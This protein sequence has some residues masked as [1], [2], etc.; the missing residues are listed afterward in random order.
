[1][2]MLFFAYGMNAQNFA[3][4]SLS[5]YY[6]SVNID[7]QVEQ[8]QYG[9]VSALKVTNVV[10]APTSKGTVYSSGV[11]NIPT[12][13]NSTVT[14][15]VNIAD[16]EIVGDINVTVTITHTWSSDLDLFLVSPAGT[17]VELST[18]NGGNADNTYAGTVFDDEATESII[19]AVV[20]YT[21]SYQPEGLLSSFDGELLVGDWT[22]MVGDDA[23]GDGGALVEWSLDVEYFVPANYDASIVD[24]P[25]L[26]GAVFPGSNDVVV[27]LSNLGVYTMT[28][29][30]VYY[31]IVNASTGASVASDVYSWSGSLDLGFSEDVTIGSFVATAGETYTITAFSD[32]VGDEDISND[33]YTSTFTTYTTEAIPYSQDFETPTG[34]VNA[35]GDN[36]DWSI[37]TAMGHGAYQDHTT[38]TGYFAGLD[39]SS[40]MDLGYFANFLTPVFDLS[41]LTAPGLFFYYQSVDDG[42]VGIGEI[43]E[44]HVDVTTDGINWTN[45]ILVITEEVN[46][47]TEF[48][49]NIMPYLGT[50]AQFRFRGVTT[51]DYQSDPS[52][53]DFEIK[54]LPDNDLAVTEVTPTGIYYN[55]TYTP[56]YPEVS[57][58]NAGGLDQ[59]TYSVNVTVTD[60]S[61]GVEVYNETVVDPA[62]ITA[63]G[64]YTCTMTTLLD[65]DFATYSITAF[66]DLT[67]DENLNNN[68]QEEV[69]AVTRWY[70]G[71]NGMP[72]NSYLMSS[73][74]YSGS[75]GNLLFS[76]G[77]NTMTGNN[78]EVF[79][80]NVDNQTWTQTISLP[81]PSVVGAATAYDDNI[82]VH[83]GSSGVYTNT[84]LSFDISTEA[85][86]PIADLPAEIAW[87]SATTNN[88]SIYLAGGYD[89]A[90]FLS[91]VY[92][93]DPVGDAWTTLADLP[94]AAMGG[95]LITVDNKL[96]YVW[97]IQGASTLDGYAMIGEIDPMDP[98]VITW[99][100]TAM[101]AELGT[102]K[103][104]A[105]PI[106]DNAFIVTSGDYASWA[107]R[108]NTYIYYMATDEWVRIDD[109]PLFNLGYAAGSFYDGATSTYVTASGYNGGFI[110]DVEYLMIDVNAPIAA[111]YMPAMNEIEVALDAT[112]SVEFNVGVN[113]LYTPTVSIFDGTDFVTVTGL[114]FDDATNTL[115]I[116]HD[117][118]DYGT[119]YSVTIDAGAFMSE[120]L[121]GSLNDDIS[122]NFTTI[123][124]TYSVTFNVDMT[125]P[126]ALGNFIVGTDVVYLTGSMVGWAEPGTDPTMEMTDVD[127]DFIYS[128]TLQVTDGDAEYKYFQNAGWDGGEWAGG[129][130]RMF[131]V[132]G[133]DLTLDDVWAMEYLIMFSVTDGT[134]ALEGASVNIDGVEDFTNVDGLVPFAAIDGTYSYTVS[135]A[136]YTVVSDDAIVAGDHQV[137]DVVLDPLA[138]NNIFANVA[139]TPNP[140]SG[141]VTISADDIYTVKVINVNGQV[142]SSMNMTNTTSTIDISNLE[143]GLYFVE[144]SNDNQSATYKIIKK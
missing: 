102:Y 132:A 82:F 114:N 7:K 28:A 92:R 118:F 104:T 88:G 101:P 16:N 50:Y 143:A 141:L 48:S 21:G 34:W 19:T 25:S 124:E 24:I 93:Y 2:V 41:G 20:P 140:T 127:G 1:M 129:E 6:K 32:L 66:V 31:D 78:N 35:T 39:D 90:N 9:I 128:I 134:N 74:A 138:L 22:L 37:V 70:H 85:W 40:P 64:T 94:M 81:A 49:V 26:S 75:F 53:D 33:I 133:S 12:V 111:T 84:C 5:D 13:D 99:T 117:M 51:G 14:S 116:S 107:P 103:M 123:E 89:G 126:I 100:T 63:G 43:S 121:D 38:G 109:K 73:A 3:S 15:I 55:G 18:D 17:V 113:Q 65:P 56:E 120:E 58:Y 87:T 62:T 29:C 47:W 144:L 105:A 60:P 119:T 122:W 131:T 139:I 30:D 10:K 57:I 97:G 68:L 23:G 110:T 136:N 130:N 42:V 11:V 52:V 108:P 4:T 27:T 137:I 76:I 142:L 69:L 115:E 36:G 67:G 71:V 8:N 86:N 54:Q 80:Y 83:L 96:V 77:G 106:S 125:A 91:S 112:V 79:V 44:L 45:D 135:L 95:S 46:Q 98:D 59:S 72:M 61:T